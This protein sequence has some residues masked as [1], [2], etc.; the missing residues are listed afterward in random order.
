MAKFDAFDPGDGG[1]IP[2]YISLPAAKSAPAVILIGTIFGVND[3]LMAHADH[4]AANGYIAIAPDMF[5]RGDAGA[6]D[7]TSPE[8]EVRAQARNKTYDAERGLAD[9]A[10]IINALTALPEYN[11][12][13]AVAGWC[14]GGRFAFL[15][16]A[17]F[18]PSAIISFH[19]SKI[20]SHLDEAA[21]VTCPA[22]LHSGDHDHV[23]PLEELLATREALRHNPRAEVTIYPGIG[24]NFTTP[25]R[26]TYDEAVANAAM[27]NALQLLA[28]LRGTLP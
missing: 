4:F 12:H 25:G 26:D 20:G 2:A 5:W 18:D 17:R 22:T 6:L 19:G 3:T 10:S 8:H 16:A 23:A 21:N 28:P 13:Y 9:I 14:F 7:W 15:S 24:H 1:R 27:T 11:G